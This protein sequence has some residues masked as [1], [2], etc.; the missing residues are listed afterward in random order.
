MDVVHAQP[1]LLAKPVSLVI[2]P[3]ELDVANVSLELTQKLLAI[4]VILVLVAN[5]R[6]MEQLLVL[7]NN[8]YLKTINPLRTEYININILKISVFEREKRA[9]TFEIKADSH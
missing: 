5:G 8:F 2:K 1:P 4:L 3:V 7:V 6:L 9:D